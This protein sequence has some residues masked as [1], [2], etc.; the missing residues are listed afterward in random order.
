MAGQV[1]N[2]FPETPKHPNRLLV[3]VLILLTIVVFG[4][5]FLNR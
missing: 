2:M 5:F 4:N 1:H 3:I